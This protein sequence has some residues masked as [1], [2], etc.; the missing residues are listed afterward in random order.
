MQPNLPASRHV[1]SL[2]THLAEAEPEGLR[3]EGVLAVL[4]A[5]VW[6]EAA[7]LAP[8]SAAPAPTAAQVLAELCRLRV[9]G[10]ALVPAAR[11]GSADRLGLGLFP[12][13][14]CMNHSCLPNVSPYFEVQ[15]RVWR[16]IPPPS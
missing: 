2:E 14:S 6:R 5:A 13:A 1:A 10:V 16:R 3:E 15:W 7:R 11:A 4:G 9:N 12:V 8:G